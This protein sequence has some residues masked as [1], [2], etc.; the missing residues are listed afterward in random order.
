M[1]LLGEAFRPGVRDGV[2][3][4]EDDE[5]AD[6][7]VGHDDG[8]GDV[9]NQPQ[10]PVPTLRLEDAQVEAEDGDLDQVDGP[11]E[12]DVVD[13]EELLVTVSCLSAG[14]Q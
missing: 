9:D 4:E 1:L 2:A 14:P 3:D 10:Q 5:E 11:G 13:P 7:V 12:E 8:D 6:D